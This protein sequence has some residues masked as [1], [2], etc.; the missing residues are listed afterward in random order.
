MTTGRGDQQPKSANDELPAIFICGKPKFIV[1]GEVPKAHD[2]H[3][4]I[5]ASNMMADLD[6]LKRSV[7]LSKENPIHRENFEKRA[8][9]QELMEMKRA[10]FVEMKRRQQL[11]NDSEAL[12]MLEEQ[13]RSAAIAKDLSERMSEQCRSRALAVRA[14]AMGQERAALELMELAQEDDKILAQKEEQRKL[15]ESLARQIEENRLRRQQEAAEKFSQRELNNARQKQ[16]EEEDR[17]EQEERNRQKALDRLKTLQ[18]MQEKKEYRDMEKAR[19]REELKK[20]LQTQSEVEDRKNKLEEDRVQLM[21][22]HEEISTRIGQQLF[23]VENAKQI[24]DIQLLDLLE[25][26]YKAKADLRF[27]QEVQEK[28]MSRD[29]TK[30][31]MDL[32]RMEMQQRKMDELQMKRDEISARKQ[33]LPNQN[34]ETEREEQLEAYRK[35]KAHGAMLLSMIED[36]HVRRAEATAE[37]LQYFNLK[38]KSDDERHALEESERLRMLSAVPKTVLPYLPKN[39]LSKAEHEYFG[40]SNEQ[41]QRRLGSGDC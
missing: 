4:R 20:L 37:H 28:T 40:L 21:R 25:A 13:L 16:I 24:R 19:A 6:D 5:Y 15:R 35:R 11:R 1:P 31:E 30:Q 29:R 14:K 39:V 2:F 26:E 12:R 7:A 34:E 27:R 38:K 23:Q 9:S 10:E 8:I 32:Y 22:K 41:Q 33:E 17:V 18:F 36:N 3:S